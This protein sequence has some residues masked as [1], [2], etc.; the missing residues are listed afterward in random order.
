[1]PFITVTEER[2]LHESCH[3]QK[4][5]QDKYELGYIVYHRDHHPAVGQVAYMC[6]VEDLVGK[7]HTAIRERDDY[8]FH[9][10]ISESDDPDS[11]AMAP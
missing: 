1:M 10:E 2:A 8:M 5:I 11:Y 4:L 3:F 9:K 6:T 7:L